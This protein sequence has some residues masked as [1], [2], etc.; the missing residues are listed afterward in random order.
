MSECDTNFYPF[1][2]MIPWLNCV[3]QVALLAHMDSL[4]MCRCSTLKLPVRR[5]GRCQIVIY[6]VH[7]DYDDMVGLRC[8]G[9][10]TLPYGFTWDVQVGRKCRC[11]SRYELV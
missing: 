3:V 4:G 6:F 1:L 10:S 7:P 8:T 5:T 9:R 11:I 2:I